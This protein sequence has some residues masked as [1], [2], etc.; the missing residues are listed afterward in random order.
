[1]M[2]EETGVSRDC[3]GTCRSVYDISGACLS[4][5]RQLK[6]GLADQTAFNSG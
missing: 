6:E 5:A 4:L 2:P 3:E 1:M